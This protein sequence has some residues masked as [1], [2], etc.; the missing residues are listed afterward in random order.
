M[1]PVAVND[2]AP[3][4]PVCAFRV[5][6]TVIVQEAPGATLLQLLPATLSGLASAGLFSVIVAPPSFLYVKAPAMVPPWYQS[7]SVKDDAEVRVAT[8]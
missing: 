2:W 3:L 4:P 1:A 5:K 7:A 8:A 6:A